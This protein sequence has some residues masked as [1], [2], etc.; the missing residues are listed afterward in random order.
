MSIIRHILTKR[1]VITNNKTVV[2]YCSITLRLRYIMIV[3]FFNNHNLNSIF[4][5]IVE[6]YIYGYTRG[7]FV[8]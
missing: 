7:T 5:F 3:I 1:T 6:E 4:Y 8:L 2:G